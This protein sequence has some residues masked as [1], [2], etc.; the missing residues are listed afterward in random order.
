MTNYSTKVKRELI[1]CLQEF[2]KTTNAAANDVGIHFETARNRLNELKEDGI[3]VKNND[4]WRLN[5]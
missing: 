4:K 1:E 5:E 2:P 3:I